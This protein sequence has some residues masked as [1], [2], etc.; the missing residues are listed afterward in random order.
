MKEHIRE[1][2]QSFGN[3]K[4]LKKIKAPGKNKIMVYSYL[5]DMKHIME[6]AEGIT[7][8]FLLVDQEDLVSL[9]YFGINKDYLDEKNLLNQLNYANTQMLYGKFLID[10]DNDVYWQYSFDPSK[11]SKKDM[12]AIV[13]GFIDGIN[14]LLKTN[15][16]SLNEQ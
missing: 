7:A 1:L 4:Y 12:I 10:S 9:A 3:L 14:T 6:D 15:E 5:F 11:A 2:F 16:D 13:R 8:N